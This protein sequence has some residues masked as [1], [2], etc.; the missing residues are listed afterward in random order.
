MGSP[1]APAPAPCLW[2]WEPVFNALAPSWE[3][4]RHHVKLPVA[5]P[6]ETVALLGEGANRR[7]L[8]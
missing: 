3:N 8:S 4:D 7:G 1:P 2:F 6:Q 5:E